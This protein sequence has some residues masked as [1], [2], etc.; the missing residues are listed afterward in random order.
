MK[1]IEPF[2]F[3]IGTLDGMNLGVGLRVIVDAMIKHYN[4][5]VVEG[6]NKLMAPQD[7]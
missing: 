7:D 6:V 1:P 5:N 2:T 4:D 3:D